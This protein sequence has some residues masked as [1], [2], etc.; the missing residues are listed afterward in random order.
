MRHKDS[1]L[2]KKEWCL[3]LENEDRFPEIGENKLSS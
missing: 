1:S 2:T 3:F